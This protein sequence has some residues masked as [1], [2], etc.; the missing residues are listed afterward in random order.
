MHITIIGLGLTIVYRIIQSHNGFIEVD[1]KIGE[2]TTFTIHLP[3]TSK[4]ESKV[5]NSTKIQDN[6]KEKTIMVI[7]DSIDLL[8]IVK[9]NF[10]KKGID[11]FFFDNPIHAI[12]QFK[13]HTESIGLVL[14][15]YL[16]PEMNGLEVF[17][18]L[19]KYKP[20]IKAIIITGYAKDII[21]SKEEGILEILQKP[22]DFTYLNNLIQN[23]VN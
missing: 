19:K 20:E 10:S 8:E 12:E 15:D 9:I 16:M 11:G 18:A 2:G 5:L 14:I 4:S 1:S 6:I 21:K 13:K 23:I 3:G 22:L 7:D 17:R